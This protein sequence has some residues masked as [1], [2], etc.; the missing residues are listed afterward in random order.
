MIYILLNMFMFV[1]L[2]VLYREIEHAQVG[3]GGSRGCGG[4]EGE[5]EP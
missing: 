3:K 5:K 1:C 2:F 4:A